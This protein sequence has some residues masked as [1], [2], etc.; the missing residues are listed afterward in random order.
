MPKFIL[1]S[2]LVLAVA[3]SQNAHVWSAS[4]IHWQQENKDGSKYAVLEGDRDKPDMPFS[5]AFFLPDGVW[6]GPHFHSADA[7]VFVVSGALLLG[8]GETMKKESAVR[9]DAGSYF[10]V[11]AEARHWE[12]AKGDTLIIGVAKGRWKTTNLSPAKH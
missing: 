2:L 4:T 7:R 11:P 9:L 6:V 8:E 5:Y 10:L 1:S 3:H 12:G